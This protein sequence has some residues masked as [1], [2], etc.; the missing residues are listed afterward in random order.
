MLIKD[1][2]IDKGKAFDWGRTS[3]DYAKYRDIYPKEFYDKIIKRKLCIKGQSVLDIGTGTGVIPRNLY[4]YGAAWTAAD[5]S[6][7]QIEQAKLLSIGKKIN[8]FVSSTEDLHFPNETFDI[9]TACQCFWYFKHK[10]TAPNFHKILKKEGRFLILYMA[11]LPFDDKIARASEDLVLKYSPNWSGGR[12]TIHLQRIF[13]TCTSRR[14][15][16]KGSFYSRI[17]EWTDKSLPWNRRFAFKRRNC[18][19]GNRTQR[20][21]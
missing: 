4:H 13:S 12:E 18:C 15:S 6:E 8:Y 19:M 14:I 2:N 21:S 10:V 20:T 9:I 11:W 5:I 3:S 16:T 17:M 1:E 7:N